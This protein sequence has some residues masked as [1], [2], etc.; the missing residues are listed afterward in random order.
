MDGNTELVKTSEQDS[1]FQIM[2]DIAPVMIWMA[3]QD[4][5]CNFF[6]QPWLDFTG[7]TMEKEVGNGWA[8][9][10]HKDDFQQCLDIYLSSFKARID[11][12]MEYRLRRNDGKYRW[13][14]DTGRP[15]F[16]PS[17]EFSGYIGSCIDIT[18][19]KVAEEKNQKL[20]EQFYQ[21][22]KM[23]AIGSLAASIVHDLK[24]LIIVV[25]GNADLIRTAS[26]PDTPI[27]RYA[28]HIFQAAT[29]EAD[30][31]QKLMLF[32]RKQPLQHAWLDY[33]KL[34]EKMMELLSG[35]LPAE[36]DTT[37][38]TSS[39]LWTV[40]GDPTL[41]EQVF[42]NLVTNA[43]DAMPNGGKLNIMFSNM[44]VSQ[45]Y[46]ESNR[47]AMVGNW[48]CMRISDTGIGMAPEIIE[49][50]F[51]PFF[52][53]KP[54]GKGTGLGLSAVYGIVKEHGGW[55]EVQS[56]QGQGSVFSVFIPAH[57]KERLD[58]AEP[59]TVSLVKK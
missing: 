35:L 41:L 4:T 26:G 7:R 25:Q 12:R 10:V 57:P 47:A 33:G 6:N 11:F 17:G 54:P 48:V 27:Y 9:G 2:A 21:S 31:V 23:E 55:V 56:I 43:R 58:Q 34:S 40:N 15:M 49:H 39:D 53:T 59:S 5:L 42:V 50:L 51:E 19:L 38:N 18:D 22:Q 46:L 24:N 16:E 44:I 30:M 36:I 3:G 20:Q 14:L 1:R 13:I 32:S 45:E 29:R 37:L 52:T 8:D 28:D